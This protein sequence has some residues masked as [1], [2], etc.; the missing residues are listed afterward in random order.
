[1]K[2]M[3]LVSL[4][5]AVA[6]MTVPAFALNLGGTTVCLKSSSVAVS[7]VHSS[8]NAAFNGISGS[9]AGNASC[10]TGYAQFKS[11]PT[12]NT[13]GTSGSIGGTLTGAS[14]FAGAKACQTGFGIGTGSGSY[15]KTG[16][17]IN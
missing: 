6:L 12:I 11:D 13:G 15:T 14:G 8:S 4:V 7:A 5:L 10:A 1:M 16:I 9:L 2:K 3:L 17:G